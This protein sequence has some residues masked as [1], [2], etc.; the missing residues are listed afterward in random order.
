MARK[1]HQALPLGSHSLG[2]SSLLVRRDGLTPNR[3]GRAPRYPPLGAKNIRSRAGF[4]K[5]PTPPSCRFPNAPPLNYAESAWF[6]YG[7][8]LLWGLYYRGDPVLAPRRLDSGGRGRASECPPEN[9]LV[10][11]CYWAIASIAPG[12]GSIQ[13]TRRPHIW[14]PLGHA[15]AWK[16][17]RPLANPGLP[18][19]RP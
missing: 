19:P 2:N 13:T 4:F 15:R 11:D 10:S 8:G 6:F 14:P 1:P 12:A 7:G 9:S 16:P 3:R 18:T 5:P 17:V